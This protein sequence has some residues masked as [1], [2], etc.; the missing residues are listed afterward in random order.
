M[1]RHTSAQPVTT[2]AP[3]TDP[4]VHDVVAIGLGPF[5]LGL[6]ALAEPV[7]GL[8]VVVLER[9]EEFR[10][11]PGLMIEGTTLQVPFLAD[12][13]TLADPTS[14]WSFLN[15]LKAV[16]RLYPFYIRETFVPLR[17]EYDAYCRWVAARLPG[18]RFG[19][20]VVSVTRRG[21][22]ADAVHEIVA[23]RTDG[24]QVVVRGRHLVVGVG[25]EPVVPPGLA[26]ALSQLPGRV[27]H[28]ADYLSHREALR[29]A[30]A[31][32]IVGSG[33]SAAEIYRDL[34]GGLDLASQRL[35]WLTRSPRFA[36]MEYA[37]LTL[38][39]TSPDYT[40]Y[41]H[42]LPGAERDRLCGQNRLLY[43][44][45]S[46]RA[47]DEI[48]DL[49]YQRRV[50]LELARE[51]D[52]TLPAS[53]PTLVRPASSLESVTEVSGRL[54]LTWR[55]TE[56]GQGFESETDHVVL[57]TGYA[58]RRPSFLDGLAAHLRLD[59]RGRLDVARD[60]TVDDA[61]LVLVQ[62][63]EEHT[64]GLSAPDLGMGPWRSAQIINQVTGREVYPVEDRIAFQTF[65]PQAAS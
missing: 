12:L 10:W 63:A 16:G 21:E 20:E 64:H 57:A 59:D 33:Q 32:T 28:S 53:V 55:H 29:C 45:I 31:V 11:H 30:S 34:L 9:A 43:K 17:A 65:G 54:R 62:N 5:N 50:E 60:F 37:K 2:P 38:E 23:R 49:L 22:G 19:H 4:V 41:F 7:D 42:G 36:P 25:T 56:T 39:L 35:D 27:L 44:G 46:S 3:T 47:V 14:R 51:H 61:G 52:A 13:V 26:G 8:D 24:E 40:A 6:A 1:T 58:P 15:H 18:L 48:F